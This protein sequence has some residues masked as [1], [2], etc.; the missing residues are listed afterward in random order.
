MLKFHYSHPL[1]L[2]LGLLV[3][4]FH[5]PLQAEVEQI[6]M[7]ILPGLMEAAKVSGKV[8]FE[9][10]GQSFRVKKRSRAVQGVVVNAHPKSSV[11]LLMANGTAIS[12][13][14]PAKVKIERFLVEAYNQPPVSPSR[15]KTEPEPSSSDTLLRLFFGDI[16]IE[17]KVLHENSSFIVQTPFG[18]V[19]PIP[20]D[21]GFKTLFR[22][23][24]SEDYPM[25][26]AWE[27][28]VKL[29]SPENEPRIVA[30]D[31]Q[32]FVHP[33]KGL[34]LAPGLTAGNIRR[35]EQTMAILQNTQQRFRTK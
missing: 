28:L 29:E 24:Y 22:I 1:A 10:K 14:G 12:L 25:L 9:F 4:A 11:V 31:E 15:S 7:K 17:T 23:R 35:F 33:E 30:R 3:L 2:G 27:G 5:F 13:Q 6:E 8:F 16:V 34:L 19:S 20:N 21:Y 32:L 26:A 18:N